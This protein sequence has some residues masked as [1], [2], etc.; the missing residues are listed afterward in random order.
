MELGIYLSEH[1]AITQ[2]EKGGRDWRK[3]KVLL[4]SQAHFGKEDCT[5]QRVRVELK[6]FAMA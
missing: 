2:G 5:C 1:T 6:D 4:I 3:G